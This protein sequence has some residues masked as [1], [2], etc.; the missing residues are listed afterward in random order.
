[1]NPSVPGMEADPSSM[2]V[3]PAPA[4]PL[5]TVLVG[6]DLSQESRSAVKVTDHLVPSLSGDVHVVHA[7]PLRDAWIAWRDDSNPETEEAPRNH[8]DISDHRARLARHIEEAK[9]DH[10]E[11]HLHVHTGRPYQVINATALA[12]GADLIVLGPHRP[13][14]AFDGLLGSTS[15]RVI[16]TSDTPCL[17][18]N[19]PLEAPPR[20]IV[21]ATDLSPHAEGAA[22]VAVAWANQWA[23]DNR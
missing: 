1:M 7:E 3:E 6:T 9:L 14:R 16:R 8:P 21:V 2:P 23:A 17:L 13:W 5:R 22:Q 15:E 11:P 19:R 20:R 10:P 4:P 18:M 12:V